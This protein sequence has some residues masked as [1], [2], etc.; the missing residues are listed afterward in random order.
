MPDLEAINPQTLEVYKVMTLNASPQDFYGDFNI[1]L[2]HKEN[3][4]VKVSNVSVSL[5]SSP[6]LYFS[7][8]LLKCL[9]S[10]LLCSCLQLNAEVLYP[11]IS[12]LVVQW[13]GSLSMRPVS[14]SLND[15]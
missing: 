15:A 10:P 1:C 2:F 3:T 4:E 9:F 12:I 7:L 13:A 6:S 5:P 11:M 8:P 14:K